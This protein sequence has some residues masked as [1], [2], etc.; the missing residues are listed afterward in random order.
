VVEVLKKVYVGKLE[1]VGSV[2][3]DDAKDGQVLRTKVSSHEGSPNHLRQRWRK[4]KYIRSYSIG[5]IYIVHI[6]LS[7]FFYFSNLKSSSLMFVI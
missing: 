1:L 5:I 4:K 2:E 7:L 3:S 6:E